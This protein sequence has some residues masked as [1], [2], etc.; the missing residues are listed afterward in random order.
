MNWEMKRIRKTLL[1]IRQT[2]EGHVVF[3]F[4]MGSRKIGSRDKEEKLRNE[5]QAPG[6]KIFYRSH[7]FYV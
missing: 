6:R 4:F 3:L 2:R 1:I 7:I 5:G